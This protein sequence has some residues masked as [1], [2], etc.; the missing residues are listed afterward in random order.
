[1]CRHLLDGAAQESNLP[2]VGL[3]RLTGFE[4]RKLGIRLPQIRLVTSGS[5]RLAQLESD[6]SGTRFGTRLPPGL[7]DR[8][9]RRSTRVPRSPCIFEGCSTSL[10]TARPSRIPRSRARRRRG[11]SR[12]G[13][14][15]CSRG[16]SLRASACANPRGH[17]APERAA[18]P[19]DI[20]PASRPTRER[21]Q[22]RRREPA[23]DGTGRLVLPESDLE[24]MRPKGMVGLTIIGYFFLPC[25]F[26]ASARPSVRQ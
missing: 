11:R 14:R 12:R 15:R 22:G 8:G 17:Y 18:L 6:G 25:A 24:H 3:P 20:P 1:M 10:R 19:G 7:Q 9:S 21:E 13:S 16:P 23:S 4:D 5:V 26:A 2:S